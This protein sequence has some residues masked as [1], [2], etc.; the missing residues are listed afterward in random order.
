MN[1]TD[2]LSGTYS[3]ASLKTADG[4]ETPVLVR[5]ITDGLGRTKMMMMIVDGALI[6]FE[7]RFADTTTMPSDQMPVDTEILTKNKQSETLSR[8]Q[9]TRIKLISADMIQFIGDPDRIL[10]QKGLDE[11]RFAH[12]KAHPSSATIARRI[13]IN[14][15]G[16]WLQVAQYIPHFHPDPMTKP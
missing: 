9:S 1:S 14:M 7:Q 15:G 5:Y 6:E 2:T 13:C 12:L 3:V 4:K 8:E 10:E 16:K 11:E